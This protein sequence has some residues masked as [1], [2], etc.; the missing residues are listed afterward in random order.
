MED[1]WHCPIH[2]DTKVTLSPIAREIAQETMPGDTPREKERAM[3]RHLLN[4]AKLR[5]QGVIQRQG[6]N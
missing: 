4:Q 6:E 1:E 5:E 3:A 2:S